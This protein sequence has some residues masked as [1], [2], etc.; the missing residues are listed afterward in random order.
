MRARLLG[1]AVVAL[2]ACGGAAVPS[3][4]PTVTPSATPS[5]SPSP[6][7]FAGL[8]IQTSPGRSTATVRVR[9]QLADRP[10]PSD[11]VLTTKAVAGQLLLKADGSF[12]EGSKVVVDLSTLSSD[13]ALRD[14]FIKRSVLET[15]RFRNAEFVPKRADGLPAP[16]PA[17]GEWKATLV[18][19]LTVHGVTKEASWDAIVKRSSADVTGTATTT[20]KFGDFG[21]SVPRVPSVISLVDAIHLEL[22]F[23]GTAS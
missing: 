1:L 13:I 5:A 20:V 3:A 21:M 18:G 23:E 7:A 12:A 14:N 22:Q 2:V 19:D 4:E 16:L 17:S 11:A 8:R 10:L 6:V 9:E 15:N